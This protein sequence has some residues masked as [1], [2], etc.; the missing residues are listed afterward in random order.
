VTTKTTAV[1]KAQ[2]IIK[3]AAAAAKTASSAAKTSAI[4]AQPIVAKAAAQAAKNAAPAAKAAAAAARTAA[5]KAQ[6]AVAKAAAS[7]AKAVVRPVV[8]TAIVRAP[9]LFQPKK[10]EPVKAVTFP[11]VSRERINFAAKQKKAPFKTRPIVYPL[12]L[13]RI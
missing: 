3:S 2:P 6:P 8:K 12:I 9:T 1:T 10:P 13:K 5:T 4:K 7:A 11:F